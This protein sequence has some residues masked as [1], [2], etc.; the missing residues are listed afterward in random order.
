LLVS[1]SEA[2]KILGLSLQGVHYRIK[3]GLLKSKKE[4]NKI[5]VYLDNTIKKEKIINSNSD[6][7][8]MKIKDEQ[9]KLLNETIIWMKEQY[10]SEI[11]RLDNNQSKVMDIFKSEIELLKQAYIE[12][13]NLYK[14]DNNKT[15]PVKIQ[16]DMKFMDIK[17][18]FEFMQEHN[19]SILQIKS[20]L[21]KKIKENDKRFIYNRT[22]KEVLI[23]K[24]DFLDL[25]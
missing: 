4:N 5:L 18:F 2:S 15:K 3:K 25:I 8:L 10:K 9:I 23:Y 16:Y 21:L 12:M 19:K 1:T 17:E 14:L 6:N 24:S 7:N 22:T 20:I 13:K 11:K